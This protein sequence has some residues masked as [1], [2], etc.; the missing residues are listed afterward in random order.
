MQAANIRLTWNFE[1][2]ARW[3][4]SC[5]SSR[6]RILAKSFSVA[7]DGSA[8][9]DPNSLQ[10]NE[11]QLTCGMQCVSTAGCRLVNAGHG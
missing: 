2:A 8:A 10:H 1:N 11:H 6:A 4:F 3:T 9:S 5:F 7:T